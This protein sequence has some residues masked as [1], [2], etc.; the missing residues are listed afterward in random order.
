M[1][2]HLRA[3]RRDSI[4]GERERSPTNLTRFTGQLIDTVDNLYYLRARMYDPT[5]GRFLQTDPVVQLVVDPYV[6]SYV[7]VNNRP[8]VF[9]DPERQPHLRGWIHWSL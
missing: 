9:V 2:L 1:D 7:Y 6:A 3:V 8:T 4:G 5:T